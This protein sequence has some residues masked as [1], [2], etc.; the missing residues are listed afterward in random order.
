M[1]E[2][3]QVKV[4]PTPRPARKPHIGKVGKI[5]QGVTISITRLGVVRDGVEAGVF[6]VIVYPGLAAE[7][8][9]DG[10]QGW[11]GERVERHGD[12]SLYVADVS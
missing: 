11:S 3:Q 2:N 10:E 7:D 5:Q 9:E 4:V 1:N 12:L 6:P 8:G